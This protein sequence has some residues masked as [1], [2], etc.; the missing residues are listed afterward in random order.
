[1]IE[2]I[3]G[4]TDLLK[5]ERCSGY[6]KVLEKIEPPVSSN[7]HTHS[8]SLWGCRVQHVLSHAFYLTGDTKFIN[9]K[10]WL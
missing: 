6:L 5:P 9:Y 7:E 3:T 2:T 10:I 8:R 1:M 4:K